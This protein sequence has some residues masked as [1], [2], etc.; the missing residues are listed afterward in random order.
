MFLKAMGCG[1][2]VAPK[3][4]LNLGLV[5]QTR[6]NALASGGDLAGAKKAAMESAQYLDSAKPLLE[7]LQADGSAEADIYISRYGPLRLQSHRLVGQIH[8]GLGD[9][10]S[11]EKEFLAATEAFPNEPGSWQMLAR[12]LEVQGKKEEA[13]AAVAKLN[14]IVNSK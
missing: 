4:M 12:I 14:A 2:D 1:P 11:C 10:E 13:Q 9:L 5:F 7:Q 3:A 6:G 8:A